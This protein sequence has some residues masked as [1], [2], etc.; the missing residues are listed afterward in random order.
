M[1][2]LWINCE[3]LHPLDKGGKIRTCE[4]L[5]HLKQDHDVTYLTFEDPSHTPEAIERAGQ[6][7][8]RLIRT[9]RRI[10]RKF[11]VRFYF[12]LLMNLLSP[13]PF[14]LQ[15]YRSKSMQDAIEDELSASDYDVVVA[16]FLVTSVNFRKRPN[17]TWLLFQHNVESLIWQRHFEVEKNMLKKL[18]FYNQWK[19][20]V[21]Y[22]RAAC[23]KFDAVIAVSQV[24]RH[25]MRAAFGSIR[26]YDV[27]TG[28][29]TD[30]FQPSG[31]ETVRPYSL[32]F[33]GSMD[34]LPNDDGIHYFVEQILPAVKRALPDVTLTVVGRNPLPGLVELG[35]T[36]SS[37]TVTGR[38]D[39]VRPYIERAAA[40]IVPLR[41]GGGTRLKIYEAMAMGQCIVS[42]SVGAEGLPVRHGEEILLADSAEDF[43]DSII[44]VLT[45][46]QLAGD[47]RC[48]AAAMVRA[49]FGWDRTANAFA[50]ICQRVHLVDSADQVSVASH[51]LF[52]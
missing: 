28:V 26:V 8:D 17:A 43:A 25:I 24:E 44:K 10:S 47:L 13:L 40:Y 29:N 36:D 12:E 52:S 27:P 45:D 30:Y 33:T 7:C 35:K 38:V 11:S 31:D 15:R 48:S 42:T 19:K 1:K 41:I 4:M 21:A 49:H 51:E 34:Y 37:I 39:D 50:E 9:P 16:D 18:Y 20:M 5:E 22:E 32:V 46:E 14:V 2:I 6:Y 3:L 23:N